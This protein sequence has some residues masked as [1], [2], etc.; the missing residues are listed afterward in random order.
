M[1]KPNRIQYNISLTVSSKD[2]SADERYWA[3]TWPMAAAHTVIPAA[4][5]TF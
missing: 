5:V 4:C 3:A 1:I 2:T